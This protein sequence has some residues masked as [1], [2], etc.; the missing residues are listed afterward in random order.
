M[1]TQEFVPMKKYVKLQ[2]EVRDLKLQLQML[3]NKLND[4]NEDKLNISDVEEDTDVN[5]MQSDEETEIVTTKY[6]KPI[7]TSKSQFTK[8][9][10]KSIVDMI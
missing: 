5:M 7:K 8:S 2:R 10:L 4:F 1:S 6:T 9:L 3:Q